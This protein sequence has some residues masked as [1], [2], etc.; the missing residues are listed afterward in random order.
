LS[1]ED[2]LRDGY[3]KSVFWEDFTVKFTE[4]SSGVGGCAV[5]MAYT[6]IN[7]LYIKGLKVCDSCPKIRIIDPLKF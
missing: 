6:A 5:D 1:S 2:I 3:V 7:E 4:D